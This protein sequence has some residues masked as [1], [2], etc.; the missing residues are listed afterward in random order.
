MPHVQSGTLTNTPNFQP[1][2]VV[3]VAPGATAS[4][5]GDVILRPSSRLI[6]EVA[7]NGTP[8]IIEVGNRLGFEPFEVGNQDQTLAAFELDLVD[9]TAPAGPITVIECFDCAA[10]PPGDGQRCRVRRVRRPATTT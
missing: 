1:V 9:G 3:R 2:G 5:V 8:G 4:L 6:I 10:D 7:E